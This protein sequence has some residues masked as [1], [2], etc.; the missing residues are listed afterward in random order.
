MLGLATG[1]YPR[2]RHIYIRDKLLDEFYSVVV[3]GG[4][5]SGLESHTTQE[6]PNP[7]EC[8]SR[9]PPQSKKKK[10]SYSRNNT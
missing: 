2:N 3:A 10:N 5:F 6:M 4:G 8:L 1:L 9:F 7:S